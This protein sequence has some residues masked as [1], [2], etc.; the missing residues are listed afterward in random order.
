MDRINDGLNTREMYEL[1]GLQPE[2]IEKLEVIGDQVDLIQA[3]KYLDGMMNIDTAQQSYRD[4]KAFFEEDTDQ[5]KMLYCQLECARRLFRRYEEK[6]I[7]KNIYVDTMRCF[8]RFI[9]ECREKNGRM[10]FDRGWWTYRQ[11]SMNIFRI[12]A[13]EYQFKEYEG[14]KVIG[15][16]IPSDADLSG[17]SVDASFRQAELFFGTYYK[18]YEYSRYTCNS[19]LMAPALSPLLS[20]GSNIL[21]FQNRFDIIREDRE[22]KEYIE[23]LFQVPADT[24]YTDLPQR[25]SLQRKVRELLLQGGTVG[26]AFGIMDYEPYS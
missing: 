9:E 14:E 10:F 20:G 23:W 13:L 6:E 25:T 21:S 16:H 17:E 11:V 19:W 12:G 1:I 3:E 4:L 15:L 26:S 5:L 7:P 22:D 8:T 24:E 18:E 2:I